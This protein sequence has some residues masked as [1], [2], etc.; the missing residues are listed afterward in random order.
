MLQEQRPPIVFTV[1]LLLRS[2]ALRSRYI[3]F[4]EKGILKAA[5]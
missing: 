4:P 2:L 1:V 3:L 5:F